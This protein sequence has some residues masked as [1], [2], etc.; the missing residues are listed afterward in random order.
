MAADALADGHDFLAFPEGTRS[1]GGSLGGFKKGPFIMALSAQA[2]VAPVLVHGTRDLLPPG[3]LLLRRGTVRVQFLDPVA[4]T[5]LRMDD[6]DAL[7][8]RVHSLMS[9]ALAAEAEVLH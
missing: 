7:R 9:S 8:D 6:R 2:P 3:S 1:S 4:T 5:G